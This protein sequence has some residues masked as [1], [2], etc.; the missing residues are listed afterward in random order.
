MCDY[1]LLNWPVFALVRLL[2][3]L[4]PMN[5][6]A[7]DVSIPLTRGNVEKGITEGGGTKQGYGQM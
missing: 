3:Y 2:K 6:K 7:G 4:Q 5:M 1:A